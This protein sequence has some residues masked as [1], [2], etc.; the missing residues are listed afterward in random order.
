[1]ARL[2]VT[3]ITRWQP[4]TWPKPKIFRPFP[5][6]NLSN[7]FDGGV[8]ATS[9]T[10][11]DTTSGDAW[12]VVSIGA[13]TVVNWDNT[14][15]AH[16][17]EAGTFSS[18][19]SAVTA[20]V[21]WT[22]KLGS[23][24][25]VFGRAYIWITASPPVVTQ[26]I[27]RGLAATAQKFRLYIN[28]SG[29]LTIAD[30][31]N[32]GAANSTSNIPAGQWVRVEW[33]ITAGTSAPFEI[34]Y[35]TTADSTGA[36]TETLTGSANFGSANFDEIRFGIAAGFASVAGYWL[37]DINANSIGFPGPVIV[38]AAPAAVPTNS[39]HRTYLPARA[40]R[41]ASQP[42][43]PTTVVPSA[44]TFV[45]Q[46]GRPR[47]R[48]ALAHHRPSTP[49]PPDQSGLPAANRG[50]VRPV[51][52]PRGHSAVQ[53]TPAQVIPP[54]TFPP[55]DQRSRLKFWRAWRVRAAQPVPAQVVVPPAYPPQ[56]WRARV[57][58]LRMLPR[59]RPEQFM[60]AQ[61][62]PPQGPRSRIRVARWWRAKAAQP[63]PAQVIPAPVYPPQSWRSRIRALRIVRARSAQAVPPQVATIAPTFPP[64]SWRS[65]IRALRLPRGRSA[66]F[67]PDQVVVTPPNWPPQAPRS[68]VKFYRAVRSRSSGPVPAQVSVTAPTFPPQ[69]GRV[70]ARA[71][72]WLHV[73]ATQPVPA[74]A[75]PPPL[76]YPPQSARVHGRLWRWLHGRPAVHVAGQQ[77]V[78]RGGRVRSRI[79]ALLRG[80]G[81]QFVPA[82]VVIVPPPY[83]PQATRTRRRMFG[84]RHKPPTNGW[85]VGVAQVSCET[86]RPASGTTTRPTSGMTAYAA[87]MTS[88][89]GTGTTTRPNSGQTD[90]PCG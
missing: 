24:P 7:N 82:Q 33:D 46:P 69:G 81:R 12:D 36:P 62:A 20:Y 53:P 28:T 50:R 9:I 44:P 89:P 70:R 31:A 56:S 8:N 22:T 3:P 71:W 87:T 77:T 15:T 25:R 86:T 37:D 11:T 64:Q 26:I 35:W 41:H 2:L 58:A 19:G 59:P 16:G 13:S 29:K 32:V 48:P 18:G 23:L 66:Q 52:P 88:R 27:A 5:V 42:L 68:R 79:V 65:R 34:R 45:P 54:P 90:P 40:Y 75:T 51:R 74:Q 1:M 49:V 39:R 72:R 63:V 76:V 85:L 80:R 21:A 84:L 30:N 38:T 10:T 17:A 55:Q 47:S 14:H 43:P 61:D 60:G 6:V 4:P 83:P 67:V 78:P 73:R 57:K